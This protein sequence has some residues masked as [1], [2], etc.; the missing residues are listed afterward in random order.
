METAIAYGIIALRL[1]EEELLEKGQR[2]ACLD[3]RA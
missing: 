3:Q 1:N 2:R